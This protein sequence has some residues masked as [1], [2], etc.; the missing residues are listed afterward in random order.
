METR[1]QASSSR[2]FSALTEGCEGFW[3]RLWGLAAPP[4]VRLQVWRFCYDAVSSMTNLARRK[5]GIDT[6]ACLCEAATETLQHILLG[7]P[8]GQVV[9]ALS[10]IPWRHIDTWTEGARHSGSR[11]Q[12]NSSIGKK[13]R[14]SSQCAGLFGRTVTKN[15]W[16]EW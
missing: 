11:R 5:E 13:H 14:D 3:P 2:P 9:W 12:F 15:E 16:K 10:N 4:R 7:C 8:F 1:A 6:T